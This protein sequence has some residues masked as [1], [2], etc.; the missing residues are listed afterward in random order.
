MKFCKK[1]QEYMHGQEKNKLPGVGFKKLKKI[2]KKCRRDCQSQKALN[3]PNHVQTCPAGCQGNQN[4]TFLSCCF[5]FP[6]RLTVL[7][8]GSVRIDVCWIFVCKLFWIHVDDLWLHFW[9]IRI[10]GSGFP[11]PL[12]LCLLNIN[13]YVIK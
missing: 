6:F 5:L 8:F 12:Y 10:R 13:G 2:L 9:D 1:Y 4:L 3:G 11:L 7:I